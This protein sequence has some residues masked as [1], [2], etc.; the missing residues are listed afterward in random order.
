MRHFFPFLLLVC[1]AI[2]PVLA[3]SCSHLEYTPDCSDACVSDTC[4]NTCAMRVWGGSLSISKAHVFIYD[5]NNRLES[6]YDS[7]TS[8]GSISLIASKGHKKA[9][10]IS[11]FPENELYFER[12]GTCDAMAETTVSYLIEDPSSPFLSAVY[13]YDSDNEIDRT[14]IIELQPL[15]ARIEIRYFAADFSGEPYSGSKFSDAKAY[16]VDINGNYGIL[17]TYAGESELLNNGGFDYYGLSRIRHP[18]MLYS[19]IVE[20]AVLYCYPGQETKLVIE[21]T[22]D[23]NTYYYPIDLN[24]TGEMVCG[25]N[26]IYDIFIKKKGVTDPETIADPQTITI[27][28]KRNPWVEKEGQNERF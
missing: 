13:E 6:Y 16:L 18:E 5:S 9:V 21:G 20:G 14:D 27:K 28:T 11:Q 2:L 24:A 22:I 26:Y 4:Y 3:L 25:G 19:S 7:D 1:E 12:I 17:G 23:G 10:I 8:A 15:L